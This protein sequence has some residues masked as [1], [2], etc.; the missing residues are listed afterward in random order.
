MSVN[1]NRARGKNF[2][3]SKEYKY[4]ICKYIPPYEEDYWGVHYTY[5]V[6][7]EMGYK[8]PNKELY[9]YKYRMYRTWKYNRKTQYK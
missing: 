5:N 8:R 7:S 6:K 1:F 2:L 9:F 4:F 3:T